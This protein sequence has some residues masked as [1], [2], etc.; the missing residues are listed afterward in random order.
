MIV[1]LS[2]EAVPHATHDDLVEG[3]A[4]RGLT[5]LHLVFENAGALAS[6]SARSDVSIVGIS[7]KSIE[8]LAPEAAADAALRLHAPFVVPAIG[9]SWRRAFERRGAALIGDYEMNAARE[10]VAAA[11]AT[12]LATGAHVQHITLR[13]GGPEAVHHEGCGIGSLM[14]RLA[15]S[16]Y[17]GALVLAP[18]SRAA[19]PL[20]R[21]W[22]QQGRNW[23]CG[24]K[25]QDPSLVQLG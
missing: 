8:G 15:V 1:A 12:V 24:S 21:A 20:W 6:V 17:Q 13:G 5:A 22:L 11:F 10:N 3:A 2:S 7:V 23:G 9:A 18:S 14:A 16:A 19:L 25:Q 4:R